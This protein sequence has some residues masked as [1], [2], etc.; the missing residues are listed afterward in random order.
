MRWRSLDSS[1]TVPVEGG[2]FDVDVQRRLCV[3]VYW[4]DTEPTEVQR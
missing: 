4:E 1:A 2:R 3:P